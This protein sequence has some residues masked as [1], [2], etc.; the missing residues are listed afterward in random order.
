MNS[1]IFKKDIPNDLLF[2]LLDKISLKTDKYYLIDY[3]A[4]KKLVFNG[5][6]KGFCDSL[7]EYYYLG[8][9]FYLERDMTYK[10]FTNIVR[11]ICKH[12]NIMFTSKM[13]YNKSKYNIDFLI[14]F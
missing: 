12:N 4:Y 2:D 5:L 11:Q 1:Q 7:K 10:S 8:K 3:N 6:Y 14:Y 9:Y 13:K